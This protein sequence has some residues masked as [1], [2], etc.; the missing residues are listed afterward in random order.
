MAKALEGLDFWAA[1]D[2]QARAILGAGL[3][4][5]LAGW[6]SGIGIEMALDDPG[7]SARLTALIV[8][9]HHLGRLFAD[10]ADVLAWVRSPAEA[11]GGQSPLERMASGR[12][13]SLKEVHG[14]LR[15]RVA[16][17]QDGR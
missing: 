13:E 9:I 10:P 11:F 14:H 17:D 16:A 15:R 12:L 5:V 2:E 6:R 1:T 3:H 4:G 8:I 7:I